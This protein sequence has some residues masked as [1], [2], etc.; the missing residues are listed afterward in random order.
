MSNFSLLKFAAAQKRIC[1]IYIAKSLN[2]TAIRNGKKKSIPFRPQNAKDLGK[3]KERFNSA[4]VHERISGK[5]FIRT[6]IA[7]LK[8]RQTTAFS[9]F[10]QGV[11]FYSL[12]AYSLS[13][14]LQWTKM[15]AMRKQ[16]LVY[17]HSKIIYDKWQGLVENRCRPIWVTSRNEHLKIIAQLG[18]KTREMAW[19]TPFSAIMLSALVTTGVPSTFMAAKSN[20]KNNISL[21]TFRV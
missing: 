4:W 7:G 11:C 13:K 2:L 17:Q 15:F 14:F 20:N 6:N 19:M 8:Y 21:C 3:L 16:Q 5:P 1:S 10:S 9:E 12:F 18:I